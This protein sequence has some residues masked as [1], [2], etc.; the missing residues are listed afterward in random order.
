MKE[1]IYCNE[2]IHQP[3]HLVLYFL[4]IHEIRENRIVHQADMNNDFIELLDTIFPKPI[5][6]F[7][8]KLEVHHL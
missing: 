6:R 4:V 1:N 2:S 8:V 5:K 7:N 3:A